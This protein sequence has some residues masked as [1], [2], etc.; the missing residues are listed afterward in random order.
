[1][2]FWSSVY[3]NPMCYLCL[4]SLFSR[5]FPYFILPSQ[6]FKCFGFWDF[7]KEEI[8]IDSDTLTTGSVTFFFFFFFLYFLV[9]IFIFIFIFTFSYGNRWPIHQNR[10]LRRILPWLYKSSKCY[11]FQRKRE[12]IIYCF[13]ERKGDK[14]K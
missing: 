9:T 4:T 8:C 2:L 13:A 14:I 1:M 7:P 10:P 11:L 6:I 5:V 12:A 3:S